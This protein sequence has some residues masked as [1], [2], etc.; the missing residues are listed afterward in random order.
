[1]KYTDL[2]T[3]KKSLLKPTLGNCIYMTTFVKSGNMSLF[4]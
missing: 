2:K 3:I 1:M 4:K